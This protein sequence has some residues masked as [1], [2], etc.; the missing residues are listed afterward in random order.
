M[1]DF[2]CRAPHGYHRCFTDEDFE[3]FVGCDVPNITDD[4]D[5]ESKKVITSVPCENV[6]LD[7]KNMMHWMN[8]LKLI[9]CILKFSIVLC[10]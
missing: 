8:S 10:N 3:G 7:S 9:S 1:C 5:H 2:I 4:Y 6:N